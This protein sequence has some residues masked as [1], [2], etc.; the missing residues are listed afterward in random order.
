MHYILSLNINC[1]YDIFQTYFSIIDFSTCPIAHN[2]SDIINNVFD[3]NRYDEY[4]SPLQNVIGMLC[5]YKHYNE[6]ETRYNNLLLLLN[7]FIDNGANLMLR[8]LHKSHNRRIECTIFHSIIYYNNFAHKKNINYDLFCLIINKLSS[9]EL[10]TLLNTKVSLHNYDVLNTLFDR[11]LYWEKKYKPLF[12]KLILYTYISNNPHHVNNNICNNK[13]ILKVTNNT[14]RYAYLQ[15]IVFLNNKSQYDFLGAK[16]FKI[17]VLTQI[18]SFTKCGS[19]LI[20][21]IIMSYFPCEFTHDE[22]NYIDIIYTIYVKFKK[23]GLIK[24]YKKI[25]S[26]YKLKSGEKITN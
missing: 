6:N 3:V 22:K 20:Y 10:S 19:L 14:H 13:F 11:E 23:P 4:T 16:Y 8:F 7:Y 24:S 17:Y 25:I 18:L 2:I 21:D 15:G 12:K 26:K 9:T 1:T 5:T